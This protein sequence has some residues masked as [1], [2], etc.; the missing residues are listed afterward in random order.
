MKT[1][2]VRLTKQSLERICEALDSHVY[3]Q[4]SDEHYRKSGFVYGKGSDEPEI[5]AEIKRCNE[6]QKRLGRK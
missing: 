3:W 4:L 5:A 1:V 6:L 2:T